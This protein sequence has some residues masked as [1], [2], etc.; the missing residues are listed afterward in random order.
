MK[1]CVWIEK[2]FTIQAE[3]PNWPELFKLWE[4]FKLTNEEKQEIMIQDEVV[5]VSEEKGKKFLIALLFVEKELNKK[6]F[7][8]TISK[9]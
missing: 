6:D 4:G 3:N 8:R 7:H 5:Q 2:C 1:T 9:I